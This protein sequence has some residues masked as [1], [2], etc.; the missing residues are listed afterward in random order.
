MTLRTP[1]TVIAVVALSAVAAGIW[2]CSAPQGPAN[3]P[4]AGAAPATPSDDGAKRKILYYR[5]AM[6]LPDTSPVPKKDAMGM[7]YVPVYAGE[8]TE[9]G[10]VT[11]SADRLQKLGVRTDLAMNRPL[12]RTLRLVGTLQVNER[13]ESTVNA[14]FEGWITTLLV[15]TTGERVSRGQPLLEVYSPDLVA[16]Q[17]DYR[18][19]VEALDSLRDAD[20][21]VRASAERL[22]KSSLERLRNWDI[23]D[24]ELASLG[25]G[26]PPRRTLTL[27]S[28][29][30]GVVLEK[31]ARVGMRF[32]PGEPLYQIADLSTVWLVA[33]VFEQ[34]LSLVRIGQHATATLAA[35][36]GRTFTGTVTFISPVLQPETRTAQVRIEFANRE[37]VLKP[38]L[39]ANVE[40]ATGSAALRLTVP[41]SAV[42][43][44]GTRQLVIVDRGGGMFEPREVTAGLRG[45]GYAE[46]LTGI[47]EHETVVVDGNF[48]ID[49][50]SN[51]KSAVQGMAGHVHGGVPAATTTEPP[52]SHQH[53]PDGR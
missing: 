28:Q 48:L 21:Q 3:A 26:E 15:N 43:D 52:A 33:S 14:K 40:I 45:D 6:G 37:G 32:M 24:A 1:I 4:R 31:M 51:L 12:S 39:F 46:I 23:A 22:V 11:V 47:A 10:H 30:D 7:D 50:E 5:N 36:P 2:S 18:V 35:Y 41:D 53:P 8:D 9:S 17:Q 38:A 29:R 13:L 19:A 25:R 27:R 16:A 20:P 34:D 42:L 49:S 44:T